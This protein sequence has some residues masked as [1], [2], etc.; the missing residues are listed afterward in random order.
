MSVIITTNLVKRFL[1]ASVLTD[2]T[3][4]IAQ[5]ER[6]LLLGKNGSGK[7]T[8]LRILAGLSRQTQG[9]FSIHTHNVGY[10]HHQSM[11]YGA[12]TVSENLKLHSSLNGQSVQEASYLKDWDL[13]RLIDRKVKELS[14]GEKALLSLARAFLTRPGVLLL[15]EPSS[16]LDAKHTSLLQDML[17]TINSTCI[18]ATHD[19][20]RLRSSATRIIV[21]NDGVIGYDSQRGTTHG[22]I[23]FYHQCNH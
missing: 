18:I 17:S 1:N 20:E 5:G 13:G 3:I 7:S 14:Q 12:L 16:A 15:D 2:I 19:I 8:L 9:D 4:S 10:T 11:L 22:A 6:V 21:L 23:D